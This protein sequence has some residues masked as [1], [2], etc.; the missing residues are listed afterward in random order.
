MNSVGFAGIRA[1]R[2]RDLRYARPRL[3]IAILYLT[4]L[5]AAIVSGVIAVSSK[6]DSGQK[7]ECSNVS[8]SPNVYICNKK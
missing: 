3:V 6:K 7:F 1:F 8:G 2:L 5:T 4:L